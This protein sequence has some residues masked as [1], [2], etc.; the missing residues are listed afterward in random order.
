MCNPV[1]LNAVDLIE[2]KKTNREKDYAVI[3][4]LAETITDVSN[5]LL[6]S[7]SARELIELAA[8]YPENAAR[9]AKKRPVLTLIP[10]GLEGL[11]AALDAER[12]KFM[13]ANESRLALYMAAAEKWAQI[14]PGVSRKIADIQLEDA[15][16][17]MVD[18]AKS[19]LPVNVPGGWP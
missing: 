10:G 7:R 19:I 2:T 5:R 14:W 4:A 1:F 16:V 17:A 3:G 8:Q 11:E 6:Y 15:H 12:R 9:V 13:H 18:A